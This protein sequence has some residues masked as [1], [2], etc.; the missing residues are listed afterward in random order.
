[1]VDGGRFALFRR[2]QSHEL[3][4]APVV[5]G[6]GLVGSVEGRFRSGDDS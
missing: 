6:C 1:M 3:T 4:G 2:V 5:V